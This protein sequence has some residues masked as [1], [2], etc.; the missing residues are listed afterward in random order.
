MPPVEIVAPS[1]SWQQEFR[2][3]GGVLRDCLGDLALRIGHI[4]STSVPGLAAKD[5][6]DIQVTVTELDLDSLAPALARAGFEHR[7]GNPGD[8][9]PPE[10]MDRTR[11]GP[12]SSSRSGLAGR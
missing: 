11:T 12:S 2:S 5:I 3:L 7:P 1:A 8:H 6:I 10:P 9:R 4:G